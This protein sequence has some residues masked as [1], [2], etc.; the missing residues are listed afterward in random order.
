LQSIG[1]IFQHSWCQDLNLETLNRRKYW[2]PVKPS[3]SALNFDSACV[4]T[5]VN[6]DA[7]AGSGTLDYEKVREQ[8]AQMIGSVA[9]DVSYLKKRF[10]C[11]SYYSHFEHLDSGQQLVE[12][13]SAQDSSDIKPKNSSGFGPRPVFH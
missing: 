8:R 11:F 5:S 3:L 2:P 13:I 7:F 12:L 6:C 10:E 4:A 1:D 9:E